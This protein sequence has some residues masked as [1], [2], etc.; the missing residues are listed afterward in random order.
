MA[1][2]RVPSSVVGG[3][4][5]VLDGFSDTPSQYSSLPPIASQSSSAAVRSRRPISSSSIPSASACVLGVSRPGARR[6]SVGLANGSKYAE[7]EANNFVRTSISR[8]AT[9]ATASETSTGVFEDERLVRELPSGLCVW[10]D[11]SN[12]SSITQ[13]TIGF[14]IATEWISLGWARASIVAREAPI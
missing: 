5:V 13:S 4:E 11:R 3:T 1:S 10:L 6:N 14:A 2:V 7:G 8:F 12:S 9:D